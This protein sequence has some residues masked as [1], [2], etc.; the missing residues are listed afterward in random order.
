M[1]RIDETFLRR[2]RRRPNEVISEPDIDHEVDRVR[3]FLRD[4]VET[5]GAIWKE[6]GAKQCRISKGRG[7]AGDKS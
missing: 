6:S 4:L 5:D 7:N 1:D 2:L 3:V